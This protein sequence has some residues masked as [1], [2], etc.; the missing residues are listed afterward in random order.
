[1]A[2]N[3]QQTKNLLHDFH[4][5][6][7]FIEQLG[8]D[9]PT[10]VKPF[11]LKIENQTYES[12]RIAEICG[13]AIFEVK[14]INGEIPSSKIRDAIH[15]EI[16]SLVAEN[17]LI[18]VDNKRIRSLWYWVKREENKSYIRDHLYVKGQ[19]GDLFLSKLASLVFDLTEFEDDTLF[20]VEIAHRLKETFDVERV[21]KK[22]YKEFQ[23]QH[24]EFLGYVKGIDNQTD[25]RWY[26][27]VILN[28]LMFVYFLQR[29]GFID[30]RDTNYLQNKLENSKQ[31][32]ENIFYQEFLQALFFES[33]AKPETDRYKAIE[34]IVGKIKYLNGGLEKKIPS[35][36]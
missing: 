3:F 22:F 9:K 19:S 23:E 34:S 4:F 13:V 15:K 16:T 36:Q 2:L 8:W 26:T 33:F 18:F 25:K 29:K 1:M 5:Q 12:K 17:L 27:S 6:D 28:R 30:N 31:R 21:T 10:Q 35:K 20:V 7:L 11:P 14:A 32:G 24:K